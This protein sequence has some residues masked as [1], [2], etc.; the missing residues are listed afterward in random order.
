MSDRVFLTE[1]EI[2][3]FIYQSDDDVLQSDKSSDEDNGDDSEP[4]DIQTLS[5]EF[6]WVSGAF[7][8]KIHVFDESSSG[9]LC[10]LPQ[11]ATELSYF[12]LFLDEDILQKVSTE[13]NV[14]YKASVE[15]KP[16]SQHSRLQKWF[17][18]SA[19]ELYVFIAVTLI[20]ARNRHLTIQEHWSTDSLLH[21]PIFGEV[22]PRDRYI[23]LLSMLHFCNN[24]LQNNADKLFK[25]RLVIDHFRAVFKKFMKPFQNLCIDE[26]LVL[27]KGRLAFKQY[28]KTKRS[29]F[30][31]KLFVLCDTKTGYI[32]DFIT[33]TGTSTELAD[34]YNL[35]ISGAVVTTLLSQGYLNKGHTLFVDNWYTSPNLFSVLHDNGTNACGTV[36]KNRKNMPQLQEKLK[37]G[38]LEAK[39]TSQHKLLAQKWYD[40]RDVYTLTTMHTLSFQATGKRDHRTG[41]EVLKPSAVLDYNK[42]MGAVDKTDMLLSSV[43]SVRKSVKW[44]KKLFFHILDMSLINSHSLYQNNSGK[45]LSL[46]DYQLKVI[47]QLLQKYHTDRTP[48]RPSSLSSDSPLRLTGRHFPSY[49]PPTKKKT[50]PTRHCHVCSNTNRREKKRKESRYMCKKCN[51]GLCVVPC[52]EE[53][54]SLI[55]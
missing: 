13:T 12:E 53:Y 26:S 34:T 40:R 24:N 15:A 23:L 31:I 8:P 47:R 35:G 50:N 41:R 18:T 38:E 37:R 7:H 9:A 17:E 27:F 42:N 43:G 45:T 39:H 32:M 33:Y 5:S 54:H 28:I 20:M 6:S 29:R 19:K 10:N 46:A 36:R 44:Y 25:I 14:Y 3:D 1:K 16:P 21:A 11:D 22:M 48:R 51:V 2:L 4:S 55:N 52:F 30:G 49:V